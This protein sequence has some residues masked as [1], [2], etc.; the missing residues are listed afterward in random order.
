MQERDELGPRRHD[1]PV[2]VAYT[3]EQCW[4]DVPGGTAVA[5][6]RV[7]EAMELHDDVRLIGVAGRHRH[8]PDDPWT[9]PIPIA[10]LPLASP[11]LYQTWLR[12]GWPKVERATGPVD[13]AHATG[14]V[15]CPTDAPLV[16]TLHDLAFLHTPA[17]LLAASAYSVFRAS[18][19]VIR[20]RA[21]VVLCSSQATIDDV[22]F[23]GIQDD[24]LRLVPLGVEIEQR[25]LGRGRPRAP[26][27]RPARPVPAVRR[28]RRAAQE[29]AWSGGRHRDAGRTAAVAGRRRRRVG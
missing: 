6:L 17:A 10:H 11:W 1:V 13:V 18:L 28:H 5:A 15:P 29:P 9:P 8:L 19:E 26:P 2:R 20:R 3:L 14:L 23:A 7:A 22:S 12:L 16:V 4:H 25:D 24:R 27:V 21:A